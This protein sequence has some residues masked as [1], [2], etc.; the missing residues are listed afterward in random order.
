MRPG[1]KYY[2]IKWN[3]KVQK[4]FIINLIL[5]KL[6]NKKKTNNNRNT[7]NNNFDIKKISNELFIGDKDYFL[8]DST[9]FLLNN[10]NNRIDNYNNDNNTDDEYRK[11]SEKMIKVGYENYVYN[12]ILVEKV[13]Q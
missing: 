6:N 8:R 12:M 13:A 3:E 10:L 2:F 5:L 9:N 4:S 1:I 11:I 7:N